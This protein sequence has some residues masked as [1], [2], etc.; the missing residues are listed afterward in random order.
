M[1]IRDRCIIASRKC[2]E[3]DIPLV[4]GWAIPYGNTR[5][6]TKD[7][8][9]LEEVYGL[10]TKGKKVADIPPA[11]L[12]AWKLTALKTLGQIDGVQ[13]FYGPQAMERINKGQIVS[14]A[15]TV[16]LTAVLMA[17]E[18]IRFLVPRWKPSVP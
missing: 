3:L 18:A 14:F 15:P 8:A 16:W 2:R 4:E 13:D 17:L 6:F 10:P 5:V 9:T 7:T 12:A 1:C 11:E